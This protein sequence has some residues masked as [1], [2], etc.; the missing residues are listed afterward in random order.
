[1]RRATLCSYDPAFLLTPLSYKVTSR[2]QE[3]QD[4]AAELPLDR[5][6]AVV[7][8]SG[9]GLIHEVFN[10]Y[11]AHAQ[12]AKAFS[13][14]VAPIPSGSGNALAINLLGI[15]VS[16]FPSF[17]YVILHIDDGARPLGQDAQDLAVAALNVIK[18]KS[19]S[20]QMTGAIAFGV[21]TSVQVAL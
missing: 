6:D 20:A 8:M 12:P 5:Y 7:V 2:R 10:G 14:P 15:D 3:A 9:D 19:R 13:I 18:G 16:I 11:A 1:M 21:L 17:G 4:I